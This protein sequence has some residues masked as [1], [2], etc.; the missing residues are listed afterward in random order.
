MKEVKMKY[1]D[2]G[3]V[4]NEDE[5]EQLKQAK[6]RKIIYDEDSPLLSDEE[7]MEFK[8]VNRLQR[9]KDIVSIRVSKETLSK[10]KRYGKGY[11]SFLSRLLDLAINDKDMVKKCL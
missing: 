7:L 3:D 5:I 10:A 9:N 11:T 8:R 4:L 2:I 6:K 1:K